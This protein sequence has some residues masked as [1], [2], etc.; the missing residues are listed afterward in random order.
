MSTSLMNMP[1]LINPWFYCVAYETYFCFSSCFSFLYYTY[2]KFSNTKSIHSTV[3]V[4]LTCLRTFFLISP[5]L[6]PPPM[7]L[8]IEPIPNPFLIVILRKGLAVLPKLTSYLS[9]ACLSLP[10][11]W[12]LWVDATVPGK[13]FYFLKHCFSYLLLAVFW[14][15]ELSIWSCHVGILKF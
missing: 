4:N 5:C 7:V 8:G 2:C 10:S 6:F 13:N 14:A 11:S 3:H 9:S 12:E 1:V 15:H